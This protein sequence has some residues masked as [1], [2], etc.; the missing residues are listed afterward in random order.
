MRRALHA[1]D[2]KRNVTARQLGITREQSYVKMKRY[3]TKKA[4]SRTRGI[5]PFLTYL[6]AHAVPAT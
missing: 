6:I 5:E 1:T 2:G 3:G 4:R